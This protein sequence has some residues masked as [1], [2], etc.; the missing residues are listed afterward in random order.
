MNAKTL[1][2]LKAVEEALLDESNEIDTVTMCYDCDNELGMG[3]NP[4][5]HFILPDAARAGQD[6]VVIGCGGYYHV[7]PESV[8]IEEPNWMGIEG[9][10]I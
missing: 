5:N 9:V 7:N 3:A 10:N 8:G 6:V 1:A 2:Y 4:V